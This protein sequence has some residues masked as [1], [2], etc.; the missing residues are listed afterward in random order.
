MEASSG[1]RGIAATGQPNHDVVSGNSR[2]I[3]G[4]PAIIPWQSDNSRHNCRGWMAGPLPGAILKHGSMNG[5]R[6]EHAG[7][8]RMNS[9]RSASG[10]AATSGHPGTQTDEIG[11]RFLPASQ[12]G[13]RNCVQQMLSNDEAALSLKSS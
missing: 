7:I 5:K 10:P 9:F 3:N 6:P 11:E 8:D 4:L 2:L 1:K 13:S 12:E